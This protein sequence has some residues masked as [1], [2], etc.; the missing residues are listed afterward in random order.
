MYRSSSKSESESSSRPRFPVVA[1][2]ANMVGVWISGLV[3]S[4]SRSTRA[5]EEMVVR[6]EEWTSRIKGDGLCAYAWEPAVERATVRGSYSTP[7][8][9]RMNSPWFVYGGV[10]RASRSP[11]GRVGELTWPARSWRPVAC[12]GA[13]EW[14]V[15][16][17]VMLWL[18][19]LVAE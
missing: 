3:L 9:V 1:W 19:G 4:R 15:T 18:S 6:I 13:S 14:Y 16:M 12:S 17:M 8:Q 10:A 11:A 5:E 7:F 2:N